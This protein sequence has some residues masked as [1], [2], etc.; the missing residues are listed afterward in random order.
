MILKNDCSKKRLLWET[1]IQFLQ[2]K[3][4]LWETFIQFLQE[5]V[6]SSAGW[7]PSMEVSIGVMQ[8]LKE[9]LPV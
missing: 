3:R 2:E 8:V 9:P 5:L 6:S 7:T 4:L 1:F